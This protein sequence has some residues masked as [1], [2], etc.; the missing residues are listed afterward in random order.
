MNPID[1]TTQAF[2]VVLIGIV[3]VYDVWTLWKRGYAT[4]I[5]YTLYAGA[6]RFPIIPFSLGVIAGHLFWPNVGGFK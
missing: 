1:S 5:S 4:T 3:T 2:I 6:I